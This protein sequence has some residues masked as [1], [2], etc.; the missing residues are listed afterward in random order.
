MVHVVGGSPSC[1]VD[2]GRLSLELPTNHECV[3]TTYGI[4]LDVYD[5]SLHRRI[6][7]A[8]KG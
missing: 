3:V 7:G 1:D 8:E 5:G 2:G 6:L 4:D